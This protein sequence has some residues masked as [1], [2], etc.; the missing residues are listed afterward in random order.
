MAT[1]YSPLSFFKG[2]RKTKN[3][4]T[5]RTRRTR[6]RRTRRTRTRKS[7]K[8]GFYPSIM[9]GIVQNG[10]YLMPVALRQGYKLLKSKTRKQNV[11][12]FNK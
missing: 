5:R 11:R 2:G 6:T 8:G 3:T 7:I 4:R 1:Y 9:T 12:K 10:A